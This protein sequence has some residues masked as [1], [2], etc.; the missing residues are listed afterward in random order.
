M[1]I[2]LM[3]FMWKFLRSSDEKVEMISKKF[4]NFFI[5]IN[6]CQNSP[7]H[8]PSFFLLCHQHIN[9]HVLNFSVKWLS[10]SENINEKWRGKTGKKKDIL[11]REK[12]PGVSIKKALK[13]ANKKKATKPKTKN[14]P[15]IFFFVSLILLFLVD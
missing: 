14:F 1:L 4:W 11:N 3:F 7:T 2:I 15:R 9:F 10:D 12:V 6:Q 8:F 5:F 13:F